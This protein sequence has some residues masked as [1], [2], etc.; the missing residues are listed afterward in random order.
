ML[1][2]ENLAQVRAQPWAHVVPEKDESGQTKREESEKILLRKRLIA[3]V[4]R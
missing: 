1:P 2:R 3:T 4:E